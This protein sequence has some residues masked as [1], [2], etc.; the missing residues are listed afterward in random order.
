M[1]EIIFLGANISSEHP[2]SPFLY[3][4][5]VYMTADFDILNVDQCVTVDLN[6]KCNKTIQNACPY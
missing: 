6:S 2:F 3:V 4:G 5:C 1:T